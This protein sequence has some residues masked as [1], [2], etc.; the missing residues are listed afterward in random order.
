[1]SLLILEHI[2][3]RCAGHRCSQHTVLR[4]VSLAIEPGEL[5]T[6]AGWRRSGRTTLIRTVAGL[7]Q[8]TSGT[9]CFNGLDT[10]RR[11]LLGEPNGVALVTSH[12][13]PLVGRS[14][15]EQVAAPM[16]GRGFSMQ[17]ARTTAYR[18]MRRTEVA[19]CASVPVAR[20][21]S[22]EAIRVGLAR[23]LVTAPALLLVDQSPDVPPRRE[24]AGLLR[25]LH[26][27]AHH[28][29][30]AVILTTDAGPAFYGVDRA[31]TLQRGSLRRVSGSTRVVRLRPIP[32]TAS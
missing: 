2:S 16:L 21:S 14:A 15:L 27:I 3:V 25:L 12:F 29:A 28:D 10:T 6:V 11:S 26:A 32:D 22:M 1:V 17:R 18:L 20:L 7:M 13:A 31:F 19:S 30:V 5:V 9:V 23:A 8:P 24:A 4:D